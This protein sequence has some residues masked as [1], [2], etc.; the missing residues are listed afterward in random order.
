MNLIKLLNVV[1]RTFYYEGINGIV[2]RIQTLLRTRGVSQS[3][4]AASLTIDY[5]SQHIMDVKRQ[6][7]ESQFVTLPERVEVNHDN[8]NRPVDISM[9]SF[10]M[11]IP[12]PERGSGGRMTMARVLDYL[13]KKGVKCFVTFYPEVI[14]Y[15]YSEC[16]KAW[17]EE[18]GFDA[19]ACPVLRLDEAMAMYFDIAVATYWPGAYVLK[20]CISAS[21]KGYFVQDFEPYFHP[22]GSMAAFAEETYRLG[23]WGVCAS[24]WLAETL[25]SVYGMRTAGFLL[26]LEKSEYYLDNSVIREEN[27]VVAYI[28]QHTPRRGYELIMWALKL[29]KDKMPNVRVEIFGDAR[30]PAGKFLWIDKNHGIIGHEELRILYN[31]A[32][33]GIV[34]SFTNYSLIPNEMI[35]CG[36]AVVDL[37][38]PCM[39]SAFPSGVITLERATPQRLATAAQLLLTNNDM[40]VAQVDR[41]FKYVSTISWE[42]SL[43]SIYFAIQEFSHD[44]TGKM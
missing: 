41:G 42:Q 8:G 24:P 14:E 36:C 15:R 3:T 37:D 18:F 20:N 11:L 29:L 33:V 43:D 40:R 9:L 10:L 22:P 19:V 23:L 25:S 35:A 34:T 4:L 30:L 27:L 17:F 7:D 26:G 28:R 1:A 39:R 32:T 2:A 38:T 6:L 21:S 44:Q 16:E 12:E 13:I 31:R 5:S